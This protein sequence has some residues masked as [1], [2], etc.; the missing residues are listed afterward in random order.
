MS[1]NGSFMRFIS[2]LLSVSFFHI[3]ILLKILANRV[4]PQYTHAL[5]LWWNSEQ[6]GDMQ[7]IC[8]LGGKHKCYSFVK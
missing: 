1:L 8:I 2:T 6:G 3:R 5:I 4:G 7:A